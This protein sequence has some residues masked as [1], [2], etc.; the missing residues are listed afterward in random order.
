MAEALIAGLGSAATALALVAVLPLFATTITG[1]YRQLQP[2]VGS[3]SA[4][5]RS[6]R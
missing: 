1:A 6:A 2:E 4:F 5:T 3:A